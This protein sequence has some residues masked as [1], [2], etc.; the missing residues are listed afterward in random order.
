MTEKK[1]LRIIQL[2]AENVKRLQAV[3]IT[4]EGNLEIIGGDNAQGK[5]SVLDSIMYALAG[6]KSIPATPI[7]RGQ[8]KARVEI[9]LG[10]IKVER[11]F[12]SKGSILEV[13][14]NGVI[15]PSPQAILD[16]LTGKL[17]FDPL[18]FTNM[19]AKIQLKTLKE[20][21]GI[22]FDDLEAKRQTLYAERSEINRDAKNLEGQLEG[23]PEHENVPDSP[24]VVSDILA[25]IEEADRHNQDVDQRQRRAE[26]IATQIVALESELERLRER[27]IQIKS[28]KA[29]LETE[30]GSIDIPALFDT[31][32]LKTALQSAEAI[33]QKVRDAQERVRV[34]KALKTKH[35]ESTKITLAI[36]GIDAEKESRLASAQF[37]VAGLSFGEDGVLLNGLPLEQAS[38]AESLKVS[39]AMGFA[40]NPRL[41]VLLI[42]DGSL[43]DANSLKTVAEMAQEHDGQVWI[44]VVRKDKT[45][46]VIIEDGLVVGGT[47]HDARQ[48]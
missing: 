48:A 34:E 42:R 33:N 32:E 6:G 47:E 13:K 10:E 40:L 18:A 2:T 11:R 44:E 21:V 9:D 17:T 46:S 20:L 38:A 28:Q 3:T 15:Q 43:L 19:D 14:S 30:V 31:S 7:R 5:T 27:A 24:V 8:K 35:Q 22:N 41:K 37:P 45:C 29:E 1:S 26:Q 25:Q 39:V 12:T 36:E 4:P 16:R 23:I